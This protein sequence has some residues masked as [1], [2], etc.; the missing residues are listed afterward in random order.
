MRFKYFN[1]AAV[2]L[3]L[4]VLHG[5]AVAGI[6]PASGP[7][8]QFAKPVETF[9]LVMIRFRDLHWGEYGIEIMRSWQ[10]NASYFA[11]RR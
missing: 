7:L 5:I 8:L 3:R 6:W 4:L 9:Y 10:K 11:M 1:P 2:D